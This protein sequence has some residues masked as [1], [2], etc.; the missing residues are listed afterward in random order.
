M[1][2][3]QQSLPFKLP[4]IILLE[5]MGKT[6]KG[7]DVEIQKFSRLLIIRETNFKG[8]EC[9]CVCGVTSKREM[10][11]CVSARLIFV[12]TVVQQAYYYFFL[13]FCIWPCWVL[14]EAH[15]IFQLQ[16]ELSCSM[17]DLVPQRGIELSPLP[18]EHRVLATGSP[19]TFPGHACIR[20]AFV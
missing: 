8:Q 10:G 4:S 16:C 12:G 11:Q 6:Q 9:M 5:K 20:C 2:L 15:R 17:Q 13:M 14:T 1:N 19:G 18:R 7:I 3:Q